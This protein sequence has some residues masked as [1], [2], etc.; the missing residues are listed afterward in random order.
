MEISSVTTTGKME[1][2]LNNQTNIQRISTMRAYLFSSAIISSVTLFAVL[3]SV[4]IIRF[5][6]S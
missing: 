4:L 2:E 1:T 3:W 5:A 6:T